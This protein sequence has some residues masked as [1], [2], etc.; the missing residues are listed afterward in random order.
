MPV[1]LEEFELGRAAV[2]ADPDDGEA[3]FL[4]GKLDLNYV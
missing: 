3:L 1:F 2:E 4:L